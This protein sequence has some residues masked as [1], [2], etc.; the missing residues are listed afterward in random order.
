MLKVSVISNGQEFAGLREEWDELLNDSSSNNVFL[1]FDWIYTWW[2]V[3]ENENRQLTIIAVRD[4]NDLVA[5][6]PLYIEHKYFKV[7]KF[8]SAGYP[9]CPDYLSIIIR[10]GYEDPAVGLILKEIGKLKWDYIYLSDI[11]SDSPVLAS[12]KGN[13]TTDLGPVY[14][15]PAAACHI[16]NLPDSYDQ[17]FRQLSKKQKYKI[18]NSINKLNRNSILQQ[19]YEC[20]PA[21]FPEALSELKQLNNKRFAGKKEKHSSSGQAYNEFHQKYILAPVKPKV[22]RMFKLKLN[23]Q[24]AAIQ[25]IYQYDNKFYYY[26]SGFDPENASYRPGLLLQNYVIKHAIEKS[27]KCFDF[28][29]GEHAYKEDWANATN[30]TVNIMWFSHSLK[31]RLSYLRL[32]LMPA[33]K[34]NIKNIMGL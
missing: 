7:L 1:T 10:K 22:T 8:L 29:K 3:F 23:N 26:Q 17:Y 4:N 24:T 2:Q 11:A 15:R 25:Y 27:V 33:I 32:F 31:G 28:L 6:T 34:N 30:K 9:I 14:E 16:I 21:E 19:F 13:T 18:N 5:I 12:I 20:Q